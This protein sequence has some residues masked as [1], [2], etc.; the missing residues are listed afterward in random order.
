MTFDTYGETNIGKREKARN[1]FGGPH[2]LMISL[3]KI[4]ESERYPAST[5]ICFISDTKIY[6]STGRANIVARP[7]PTEPFIEQYKKSVVKKG[8][9]NEYEILKFEKAKKKGRAG[10]ARGEEKGEG[11]GEPS[12]SEPPPQT[13]DTNLERV[14]AV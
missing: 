8:Q 13:V 10:S 1:I 2:R 3:Y 11:E 4:N 5:N 12:H 7:L 14:S 6:F 9:E